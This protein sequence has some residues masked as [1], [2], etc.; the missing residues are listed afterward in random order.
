MS[1]GCILYKVYVMYTQF[2]STYVWVWDMTE[3]SII[4]SSKGFLSNMTMTL[5]H[6]LSAS[7]DFMALVLSDRITVG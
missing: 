4:Y 2:Y 5:A 3:N 1:V 7:L 6:S